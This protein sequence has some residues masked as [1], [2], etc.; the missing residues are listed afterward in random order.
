MAFNTEFYSVKL[1][2]CIYMAFAL[3]ILNCLEITVHDTASFKTERRATLP[4]P[5]LKF[6]MRS[7]VLWTFKSKSGQIQGIHRWFNGFRL[8]NYIKKLKRCSGRFILSPFTHHKFQSVGATLC[9]LHSFINIWN[10]INEV[11]EHYMLSFLC[12][13]LT[14]ATIIFSPSHKTIHAFPWGDLS[15]PPSGE[16]VRRK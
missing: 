2:S 10:P 8:P 5:F 16:E 1:G 14:A 3:M 6:Y 7:Q 11:T 4:N 9:Q 12:L 13:I 15:K